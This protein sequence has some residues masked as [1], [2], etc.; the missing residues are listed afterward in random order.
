[1]AKFQEVS[2]KLKD[3]TGKWGFEFKR[4]MARATTRAS[5]TR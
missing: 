1:M 5:C 2:K 4:W 3:A